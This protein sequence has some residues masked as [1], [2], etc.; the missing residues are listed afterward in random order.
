MNMKQLNFEYLL[1]GLLLLIISVAIAREEGVGDETRRL[2]MEPALCIM[3]LMG[4]W[5]LVYK[6][7]LLV[8]GAI[9]AVSGIATTATSFFLAIPE[10][11]FVN[12]G[13]LLVF[14]L[15]SIWIASRHLLLSDQID[16]NKI[17]GAICIYLLI[18]LNWALF[19]LC[20]NMA[21]QDSFHGLTSTEDRE[22]T[23]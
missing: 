16:L 7:W 15:A 2:F 17:I 18:G 1:G 10:L 13:I 12:I 3:L 23:I 11:E 22:P 5:K 8:G 6:K 20:I 19:Y 9:L 4:I 21:I 14:S